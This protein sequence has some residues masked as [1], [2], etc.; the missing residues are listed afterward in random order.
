ML[1]ESTIEPMKFRDFFLSGDTAS[2]SSFSSDDAKYLK[3]HLGIPLTLALAEITAV[4]P[5]DPI[6]YLGHWLFKYRY[7][8]ELSDLK[9]NEIQQVLEERQAFAAKRWVC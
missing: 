5:R 7:N 1:F 2:E 8:Q 3:Q 9:K 4:Q 6:H